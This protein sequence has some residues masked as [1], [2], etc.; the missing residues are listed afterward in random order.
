MSTWF[1]SREGHSGYVRYHSV[2][3]GSVVHTWRALPGV[4]AA[5]ALLG[6]VVL[7]KQAQGNVESN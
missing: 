7:F 3:S 4:K 2:H 1:D 5:G 6:L